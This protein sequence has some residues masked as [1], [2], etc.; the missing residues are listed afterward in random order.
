MGV[1]GTVTLDFMDLQIAPLE[2]D[3]NQKKGLGKC[4]F[5]SLVFH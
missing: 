5:S 3:M 4:E 1:M 2:E